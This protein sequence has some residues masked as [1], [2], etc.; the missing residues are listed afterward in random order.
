[1]A[2]YTKHGQYSVKSG[3]ELAQSMERNGELG[4]RGDDIV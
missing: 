4:R 2:L 1:M 3:C